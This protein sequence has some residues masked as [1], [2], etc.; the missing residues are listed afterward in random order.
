MD[1]PKILPFDKEFIETFNLKE[2]ALINFLYCRR[3]THKQISKRL[4]FDTYRGYL[5][6]LARV[7]SRIK[8]YQDAKMS[9]G[10]K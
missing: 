3:Y 8:S 6:M 5:K 7:R 9:S 1:K 2:K 10:Q 4:Y